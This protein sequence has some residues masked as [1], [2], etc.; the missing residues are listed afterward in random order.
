MSNLFWVGLSLA[1]Y[2]FLSGRTY[3]WE[4]GATVLSPAGSY[5]TGLG[6]FLSLFGLL[7]SRGEWASLRSGVWGVA[8]CLV[9]IFFTDW[10]ARGYSILQAPTIRGEILALTAISAWLIFCFFMACSS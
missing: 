1:L 2:G 4:S 6:F 9:G 3:F 5:T 8:L 7:G 10:M